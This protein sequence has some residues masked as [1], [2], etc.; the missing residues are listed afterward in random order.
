MIIKKGKEFKIID[1][2][3]LHYENVYP[4]FEN[5]VIFRKLIKL[6]KHFVSRLTGNYIIQ[7][8]KFDVIDE[9]YFSNTIIVFLE[10]S[11]NYGILHNTK[12]NNLSLMGHCS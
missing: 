6:Y 11:V 9:L 12:R 8:V 1:N 4:G 10:F 2:D 7:P 3:L 5:E